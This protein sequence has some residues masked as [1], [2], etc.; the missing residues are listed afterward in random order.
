MVSLELKASTFVAEGHPNKM[1][2]RGVL[3]RLDEPSDKPPNGSNGHRILVPR[4]VAERRLSSIKGMGLN[5]SPSLDGHAQRRKVGVINE[6]WIEGNNFCVEGTIWK[7]DFPEAEKDLKQANLGMSMEIGDVQVENTE[8][9]VWKLSD[10]QFLGA[11]ILWKNAAAYHKTVA[12]AAAKAKGKESQMAKTATKKTAVTTEDQHLTRA[13]IINIAASAAA[14]A[15]KPFERSVNRMTRLLNNFDERL[16]AID[17]DLLASG[18]RREEEEDEEANAMVPDLRT[19]NVTSAKEEDDEDEEDEEA[20]VQADHQ[21]PDGDECDDDEEDMSSAVDKG[22]LT[23]M[24]PDTADPGDDEPGHFSEKA[25]NKGSKTSSEDKVG[26]NISKGVTGSAA[27]KALKQKY[28]TLLSQHEEL[29]Q[30]MGS[31]EK[32]F[33]KVNAQ[34]IRAGA[35]QSRRSVPAEIGGLLRKANIE[36]MNLYA[37]GSKLTVEQVDAVIGQVPNLDAVTRM[38]LKNKFL[39]AGLME[40]GEVDRGFRRVG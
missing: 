37:S 11:T 2:F 9:P 8:S 3:V 7:H 4:N 32:R 18:K 26:E 16:E 39:E 36:P 27:Y 14:Q 20:S 17:L 34:V 6:A 40:V 33:K 28:V 13:D 24:G 10:F 15:V 35:E 29:N 23:D 38:T 1:T 30:R 31:L 19:K 5:Y 12:I 25:K 22:D 21:E